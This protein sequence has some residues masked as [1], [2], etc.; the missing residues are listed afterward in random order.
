M[1][2]VFASLV[3]G[4]G[5]FCLSTFAS[6]HDST[7][8]HFVF[9]LMVTEGV[10][11]DQVEQAEKTL[12]QDFPEIERVE[13]LEPGTPRPKDVPSDKVWVLTEQGMDP[14]PAPKPSTNVAG[15]SSHGDNAKWY[16]GTGLSASLHSQI[17]ERGMNTDTV[18]YPDDASCYRASPGRPMALGMAKDLSGSFPRGSGDLV[19]PAPVIAGYFWTNVYDIETYD[20][21]LSVGRIFNWGRAELSFT[22]L[23][24]FK[25]HATSSGG[26][27]VYA[28]NSPAPFDSDS[29]G[30]SQSVQK[31]G[32]WG[33]R[34]YSVNVF[35][36]FGNK[37]RRYLHLVP[38]IGL[39]FGFERSGFENLTYA[40]SYTS[41]WGYALP[42]YDTLHSVR[43]MQNMT[44]AAGHLG[45]HTPMSKRWDLDVRYSYIKGMM[46][47]SSEHTN[48]YQQHP[49]EAL[50]GSPHP[51]VT[52]FDRTRHRHSVSVLVR[53]RL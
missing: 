22:Q 12:L 45:F 2:K 15:L 6:A 46:F 8:D 20:I 31:F 36:D 41:A 17:V 7:R 35:R 23:M 33:G 21:N 5:L 48:H 40:A 38:Y 11:E 10:S 37:E 14:A 47:N 13:V 26:I 19:A 34:N 53:L 43:M 3:A 4:L 16:V 25:S 28:P 9:Y 42:D 30:H 51:S 50:T 1:R 18:C 27:K 49:M 39:G 24:S 32:N 29:T 52:G 44:A